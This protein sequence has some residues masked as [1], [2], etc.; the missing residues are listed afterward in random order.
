[1]LGIPEPRLSPKRAAE[2]EALRDDLTRRLA[3]ADG[4]HWTA[5]RRPL[6]MAGAS[7]FVGATVGVRGAPDPRPPLA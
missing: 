6:V 4:L 2:L 5:R 7:D 1:D 3:A